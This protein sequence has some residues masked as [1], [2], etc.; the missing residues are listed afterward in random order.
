MI[1]F[2]KVMAAL[3]LSMF[4]LTSFSIDAEA[5]TK[6]QT[7]HGVVHKKHIKKHHHRHHHHTRRHHVRKSHKTRS[8]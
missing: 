7:H 1:T 5:R 8:I 3:L 2:R 6:N 4:M